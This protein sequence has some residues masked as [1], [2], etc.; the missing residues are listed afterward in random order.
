[1]EEGR[2]VAADLGARDGCREFHNR[3]SV[4]HI[5]PLGTLLLIGKLDVRSPP[6]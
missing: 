2:Q 6:P 3:I 5:F 4:V 1:M